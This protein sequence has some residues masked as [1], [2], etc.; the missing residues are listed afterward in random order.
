MGEPRGYPADFDTAQIPAEA[1]VRVLTGDLPCARCRYNLRGLSILGVC[2]ECGTPVRGTILATVDPHARELAPIHAPLLTSAGLV[3][4]AA[5]CLAAGLLIL[6]V[7]MDELRVFVR[8]AVGVDFSFWRTV[9]AWLLV[10]AAVGALAFVRPHARISWLH[11]LAALLGAAAHLPL[12]YLVWQVLAVIDVEAP[13][14][15]T[16]VNPKWGPVRSMLRLGCAACM[17]VIILGIRPNGRL[18]VSRS[19]LMRTGRVDRQTLLVIL[20]AVGLAAMGDVLRL[21]GPGMATST[22]ELIH[23]LGGIIIAVGSLLILL[24]LV[25]VLIDTLR[26]RYSIATP[27]LSLEEI[28]PAAPEEHR[29]ARPVEHPR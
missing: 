2:P 19:L 5:S 28:A 20:A 24:G 27:A 11:S 8:G 13:D 3:L 14:P 1:W 26:L 21:G 18:L 25:G 29:P 7:R 17:A 16:A 22:S 23:T 12:A 15:Y 4:W 6:I 9:P 10:A